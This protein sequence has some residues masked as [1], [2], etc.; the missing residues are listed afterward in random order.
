MHQ[1]FTRFKIVIKNL[2]GG[3]LA[4]ALPREASEERNLHVR[5]ETVLVPEEQ[6]VFLALKMS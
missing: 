6:T 5:E 4:R 1:K 3:R 2:V